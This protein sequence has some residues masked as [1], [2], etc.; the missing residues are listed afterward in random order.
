MYHLRVKIIGRT[1]AGP[2]SAAG[3]MAYRSGGRS[4]ASAMAYRAGAKLIDRRTGRSFDYS[5]KARIDEDGFG[6]LHSEIMLP[7]TAP[8]WMADRQALLDAV[9]A[10]EIR[11]DAQLLREVE[12]SLP[13]ELTFEQQRDLVRAFVQQEFVSRGMVADL[14]IHDELASDGGRNPHAHV[15]L[16]MRH[17]SPEGFGKKAR[18][19]NA[20]GLLQQWREA[21]AEIANEML[22]AH[23]HERRIDHR[24]HAARE[25]E[26]EPDA[27]VGPSR[28]RE[29]NG[30]IHAERQES[31]NAGKQKNAQAITADPMK[32]LKAVAKEKATFTQRDIAFALRRA[33]GL[34]ADEL[35]A[36][37]LMAE[38]LAC[39]DLVAIA[40]DEKGLTR[41]A[42]RDMI[43]CELEM[44]HSAARLARRETFEVTMAPPAILSLEQKQAFLHATQGPDFVAITGVAGAGKTT[45]LRAVAGAFEAEGYR[46]RGAAL[47]S[48]AAKHLTDEA[49]I[50]ASTLRS[51]FYGWDRRDQYGRPSPTA[52]LERGDVF[53]LDEASMVG[54]EDMRRLMTEAD[55]VGA[56]VILVGDSQQLEAIDA[57]AAFRALV[58]TH[59]AARLEDVRRQNH[60]WQRVAS[61]LLAKHETRG[62]LALYR[63]SG[64]VHGAEHSEAAMDQLVDAYLEGREQPGSQAILAHYKADIASLNTKVRAGL[65]K[66]G[67][68]GEDVNVTIRE[69]KRDENNEIVERAKRAVFA[70]G[71]A[72]MF[73]KND[74][75]L[76]VR[77]GTT[78]TVRSVTADGAFEVD[79]GGACSVSFSTRD[80]NHLTHGY[81]FTV[82]K[83]EGATYDRTY[84]L[85]TPR[86]GARLGYVAL[87]RHREATQIFYSREQMDHAG[88]L[89]RAFA[90]Q[91]PKDSTLDY[92]DRYRQRA[93][94]RERT[95][96]GSGDRA[97]TL[98]PT[99]PAAKSAADQVRDNL[100]KRDA[101]RSRDQGRDRSYGE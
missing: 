59:G 98:A 45:A 88:G 92:L 63:R 60:E 71:D 44:A 19:W 73:T 91:R 33:T 69:Q 47:A 32:L 2:N 48:I 35:Q 28:G 1:R 11:E 57:G 99:P 38:I 29:F 12:I 53:I 27:Y 9:E 37:A 26:L 100:A 31:R 77:N 83:A 39:A 86:M 62:A 20:K 8:E 40:S 23:G 52:P 96:G 43:Q 17:V 84:V 18:E 95:R 24:S 87:T 4:G 74:A 46:V 66:A 5:A 58:D 76:G 22:A 7:R 42:T 15:L 101:N 78:G 89:D 14:A 68:L 94:A 93:R 70:E 75:A 30:V 80:Y 36:E 79:L 34:E 49:G 21:W 3:A 67:E 64:D 65:R 61:K 25:I 97:A 81:A 72:I 55:R 16:T 85:A 54:S 56:K 13:R 50:P 10:A 6:I 41:Y 90:R 82:H 51:T